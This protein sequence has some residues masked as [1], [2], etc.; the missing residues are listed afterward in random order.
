MTYDD[1]IDAYVKEHTDNRRLLI[2]LRGLCGSACKE[3]VAEFPELRI[4]SGYFIGE[5]VWCVKPGGG[6]EDPTV[7]QFDPGLVA[8]AKY[9]PLEAG[10]EIRIGK[11]MNCGDDIFAEVETSGH[12]PTLVRSSYYDSSV[13]NDRCEREFGASLGPF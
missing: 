1:W 8:A 2:L 4:V 6:I 13:C 10:N 3:M 7:E 5:H 12:P 11:C 9:R